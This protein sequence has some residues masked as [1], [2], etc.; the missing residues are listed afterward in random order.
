MPFVASCL[1]N[2]IRTR[3]PKPDTFR[4]FRSLHISVFTVKNVLKA[5]N[6]MRTVVTNIQNFIKQFCSFFYFPLALKLITQNVAIIKGFD[7]FM[8]SFRIQF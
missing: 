4:T 1:K 5:N 3:P 7:T 8:I 6:I 2:S